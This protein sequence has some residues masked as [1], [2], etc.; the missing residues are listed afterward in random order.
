MTPLP[1]DPRDLPLTMISIASA[2]PINIFTEVSAVRVS[3]VP[4]GRTLLKI[5]SPSFLSWTITGFLTFNVSVNGA[6]F[7]EALDPRLRHA[8]HI[9]SLYGAPVVATL[10]DEE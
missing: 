7:A 2:R 1:G 3:S 6:F 4:L 5:R 10:G 9:E 8:G